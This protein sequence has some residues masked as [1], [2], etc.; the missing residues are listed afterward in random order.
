MKTCIFNKTLP[1]APLPYPTLGDRKAIISSLR[2]YFPSVLPVSLV[3]ASHFFVKITMHVSNHQPGYHRKADIDNL[4]KPILDAGCGYFWKDDSQI[5]HLDAVV[6]RGSDR[7]NIELTIYRLEVERLKQVVVLGLKERENMETQNRLRDLVYNDILGRRGNESTA[8]EWGAVAAQFEQVCGYKDKYTREDLTLF[9]SYMR[10]KGLC[11]NTIYKNLKAIKLLASLQHWG[12]GPQ[13][14]DFPKLAMRRVSDAEVSRPIFTKDEVISLIQN[15]KRLLTPPQL[16]F[17]ALSTTYGLRRVEMVRLKPSDL[18]AG[19]IYM[20]TVHEGPKTTQLVPPEI[21][22]YLKFSQAYKEDSLT[23]LFHDIM[24]ATGMKA[25][26]GFG[27]HSIRR[28]LATELILAEASA[29]NVMRF[30]RWSEKSMRRELGMLAL[31]AK[32]NQ[33]R[34]DEQIFKIHPFLPFWGTGEPKQ[35]KK[36]PAD[37]ATKL[38]PLIGLIE[39]GEL[40]EEEIEQLLTL[41]KQ[42]GESIADCPDHRHC[43]CGFSNN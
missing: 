24:V 11:Q 40:D 21:A 9:L 18:S 38:Q 16:C 2:S 34:I 23:H 3:G 15:G 41:V 43:G 4:V 7:G 37:R 36:A 22:P 6:V 39:S 33:G 25:T 14:T 27:W 13:G 12:E 10:E 29:L 5:D 31:Y 19:T 1:V 32:K 42:K 35:V 8:K 30:M 20:N 28:A 17:L 26:G